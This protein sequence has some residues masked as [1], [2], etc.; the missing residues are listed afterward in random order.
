MSAS[1]SPRKRW[2]DSQDMRV[3]AAEGRAWD[4]YDSVYR[5]TEFDAGVLQEYR[6]ERLA[7]LRERARSTAAYREVD[8]EWPRTATV[9]R[10]SDFVQRIED[11][12]TG[13]VD[14]LDVIRVR[15]SGTTGRPAVFE[16]SEEH[17]IH[18]AASRLRTFDAYGIGVSDRILRISGNPS[19]PLV[20]FPSKAG[21]GSMIRLNAGR[22]DKEN[23]E[24]VSRLLRDY[25]AP[26]LWAQP[27]ELLLFAGRLREHL[28]AFPTPS[29]VLSHG[30]SL[31]EG[32]RRVCAEIFQERPLDLYGLQEFGMIAWECPEA[33]GTYHVNDEKVVVETDH[34]GALLITN[35]VNRALVMARYRPEDRG[36]LISERCP[37]GR[38]LSRVS[39]LAGRQRS[40][41]A[42]DDGR[43]VNVKQVEQYL[44]A[45]SLSRWRVV[46][47]RAGELDV[48][49]T[50]EAELPLQ[51]KD[52]VSERI[53]RVAGQR[54]VEVRAVPLAEMMTATGKSPRFEL[55][56]TQ[57]WLARRVGED[58]DGALSGA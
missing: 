24:Y 15:T 57:A 9:T 8:D 37:C 52:R 42:T 4:L 38:V 46:Q 51:Q 19:H 5:H 29:R 27:M 3:T 45:L 32:A 1:Q 48:L 17:L 50:S 25:A 41:I 18:A 7:E 2:W 58:H 6:S 56:A 13:E 33:V 43:F 22:I 54:R 11:Y 34:D 30:D 23:A 55:F 53:A 31:D 12:R 35:L 39:E 16:H 40:F 49:Y 20:D 36:T 44:D 10:K 14:P 28:S 47:T 21:G 26:V